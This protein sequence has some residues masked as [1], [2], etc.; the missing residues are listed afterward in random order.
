MTH[1]KQLEHLY[2]F[3]WANIN[4]LYTHWEEY[5]FD[6]YHFKPIDQREEPNR[7]LFFIEIFYCVAENEKQ[8]HLYTCLDNL[9]LFIL[10]EKDTYVN[11]CKNLKHP[12]RPDQIFPCLLRLY[13]KRR[14]KIG[15]KNFDKKYK[16]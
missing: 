2:N 11:R 10:L 8:E 7:D 6:Q 4:L 14:D 12:P 13:I 5:L 9:K 16:M 15:W 1:N 3:Y